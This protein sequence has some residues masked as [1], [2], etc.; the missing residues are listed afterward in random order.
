VVVAGDHGEGLG[1]HGEEAHGVFVYQSTQRV[2]L[3]IAGPG[4][5]RGQVVAGR[6]G[7]IDVA[8]TVLA[9]LDLPALPDADGRSVVPL[10]EGRK[11]DSVSY[12]LESL[13]PLF[14]YGWSPVRGLVAGEYK[15]IEAPRPE[16][17]RLSGDPHERDDLVETQQQVAST[18]ADELLALTEDDVVGAIDDDPQL[19]EQRRRLES[20]GYL[21]GGGADA[22]DATIDPKDGIAWVA[23]LQAG[24]RAYQTG[25]PEEGIEPL[26]RLLSR[27]PRNVPALLALGICYLGVGQP[28]RAVELNR[29]ALEIRP[30][31]DQ[32]HFNLANALTFLAETKPA[33]FADARE[34]YERALELNPR[35]ADVYLT[36]SS[37][38]EQ[39]GSDAEALA[40][41]ERARSAGVRDPDVE[42]SVAKL[43]LKRGDVEAAKDAFRRGL[44]LHPRA[45]RPLEA[46]ARITDR[47]GHYAEA[48]GYYERLCEVA[49]SAQ[50]VRRLAVI[51]LEHLDDREGARAALLRGL[52]LV[53]EDDPGREGLRRMVDDLP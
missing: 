7:L 1:E 53:G 32:A 51:R 19:A 52:E 6:V 34:H 49:P 27:N 30:D 29:R 41:L 10:F 21:G 4:V 18:L 46:M 45:P 31:D 12:E 11:A 28:A 17:Y 50:V 40:L 22:G 36:Y 38:L 48:S 35:Y 8:P 25:K 47:Q 2:P 14:A 20:L 37:L 33:A 15:F 42:T 43:E 3:I 44:E 24:R 26:E 13:F 9:L 16:L 39:I 23:D 5:P